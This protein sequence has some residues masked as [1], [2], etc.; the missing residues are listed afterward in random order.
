MKVT[1]LS[2]N[3]YSIWPVSSFRFEE[4]TINLCPAEL[5]IKLCFI[6]YLL[7]INLITSIEISG[8]KGTSLESKMIHVAT[9]IK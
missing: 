3:I 2:E 4:L 6:A 7:Y 9:L 5:R 1:V 8:D